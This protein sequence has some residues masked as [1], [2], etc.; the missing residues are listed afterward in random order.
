MLSVLSSSYDKKN[1]T[2][3]P[4]INWLTPKI[5]E[6]EV[7]A[8]QRDID[9]TMTD[10]ILNTVRKFIVSRQLI[11]FGGLAIDY[12]LKLKGSGIY[13]DAQ[14]PDFD[15]I[16]DHSVEDAYDLADILF[17]AG[18]RDVGAMRGIHVQTMRVR[19][20]FIWV[21]D[22]GYAPK[23]VY[24][25]IPTF[26]FNGMRVVHP[27]Y[28]RMDMHMALCFPFNGAPREDVF[29]RWRKDVKRF[30]LL[31]EYY[32]ILDN[33]EIKTHQIQGELKIPL[34]GDGKCRVAHHGFVA[35][36]LLRSALDELMA[37]VKITKPVIA[38]HLAVSFR[39]RIV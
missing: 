13:P 19:A 20:D 7:I 34:I 14:R 16:S 15:F 6:Y 5:K 28:Q 32:P 1:T 3:E 38:P 9:G 4:L 36:S 39:R 2:V 35:Y 8:Q 11:L 29:H 37:A 27:D 10:I 21:A 30:N 17:K 24:D 31:N 23:E 33:D 18:Y 12:A 22:I 25:K 26:D